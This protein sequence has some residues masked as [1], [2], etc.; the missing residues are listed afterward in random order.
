MP[1]SA[2]CT[3]IRDDFQDAVTQ[4]ESAEALAS[5][6]HQVVSGL[7]D[8]LVAGAGR[9]PEAVRLYQ[10]ACGLAESELKID[11]TDATAWAALAFYGGRAGNADG[12]TRALARAETL[13]EKDMY[14]QFYIALTHGR[15]R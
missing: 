13:G 15:P 8:A 3:T 2:P 7:A 9:R 12:A 14:A 5:N 1:I 11:P 4:Y 10:R 6:D